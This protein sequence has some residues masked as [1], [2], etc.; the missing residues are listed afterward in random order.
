MGG[1]DLSILKKKKKKVTR[2]LEKTLRENLTKFL[3]RGDNVF[4]KKSQDSLTEK[5]YNI[6]EKVE[7]FKNVNVL[8]KSH[9]CQFFVIKSK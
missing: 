2:F 1:K 3:E 9:W 4:R 5:W 7:I 6:W 8:R